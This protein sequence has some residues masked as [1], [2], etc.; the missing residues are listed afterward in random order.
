M[1]NLMIGII[2]FVVVII[3][4]INLRDETHSGWD[5]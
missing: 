2:V 1:S 4:F 3:L 5:D